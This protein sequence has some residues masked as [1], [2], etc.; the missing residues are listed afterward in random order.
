MG[1][2]APLREVQ[3]ACVRRARN[4]RIRTV[5]AADRRPDPRLT[6]ANPAG[7]LDRTVPPITAIPSPPTAWASFHLGP[8]T[9]HT[10]ALCILTG[11]V[12]AIAITGRRLRARGVAPGFV[13]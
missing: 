3:I 11:I 8:L 6:T 2:C 13:I 4:D 12:A 1:L 5:C 10:Y 7:T 9:V